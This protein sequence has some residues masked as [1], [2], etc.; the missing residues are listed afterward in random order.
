[1]NNEENTRIQT[2]EASSEIMN[3][4]ELNYFNGARRQ[5]ARNSNNSNLSNK[6]KRFSKDS[7]SSN[8]F[9]TLE[10]ASYSA[11]MNKSFN[12]SV[13]DTSTY[14]NKSNAEADVASFASANNSF[15]LDDFQQP[16]YN[17]KKS[18]PS[19]NKSESKSKKPWYSVSVNLFVCFYLYLFRTVGSF[20]VIFSNIIAISFSPLNI[21]LFIYVKTYVGEITEY[22][23]LMVNLTIKCIKKIF[24]SNFLNIFL[25]A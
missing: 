12:L 4:H 17:S 14:P 10:P 16:K 13:T 15:N 25:H 6:E 21:H 22:K 23:K 19:H 11:S 18:S 8:E 20:L 7:S 5:A 2:I 24:F 3:S 9:N 1:M